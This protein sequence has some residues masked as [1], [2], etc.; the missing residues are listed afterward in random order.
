MPAVPPAV[1]TFGETWCRAVSEHGDRPFLVFRAD[2]GTTTSWTYAEF[3]DVVARVAGTLRAR[4]VVPGTSVHLVLRS[5]PAFVAL[6]LAVARLGAWMVP[7]DPASAARDVAGQVR[8]VQPVLGVAAAS[9]LGVYT[10]GADGTPVVALAE[11]ATDLAPGAPLVSEAEPVVAAYPASPE[12]RLAVMFTSGTTSEPKGV[13]LTQACYATVAAAMAAAVDLRPEH[14][15]YVT[16]PMFHANAQYYCFAPAVQVGASVAMTASF[17]ASGWVS[18]ARDLEVTHASLFAAPVRMILARC[19]EDEEPLALQHVWYAQSLGAEH[20]RR[21]GALAGT[22]PRQL[23]GMTETVAVVTADR[24]DPPVHDLIGPPVPGRRV[25]LVDAAG[26]IVTQAG[27]PGELQVGGERGRDLFA[28]YLDA[29]EINARAFEPVEPSEPTPG[30]D[31]RRV[32][33]RTGDLAAWEPGVDSLRFVGRVDDVIKVAGENVSLTEVEAAL[34]QA[35]G[36]LEVAVV[37]Q[38]D[39][40][41]DQVPVAYVVA[42]DRAAPPATA[43]LEAYAVSVLA[44]AARPRAW[45]LIDELPRTGVGK[46]RRF[47]V[48]SA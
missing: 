13:V 23:Y 44:P 45:H 47:R 29:P 1:S 7:V 43:D 46:V 16:L 11:D 19:P 10:E 12:H 30:G 35:P 28:G 31:E 6:W 9:R 37:A 48:G 15:W 42:K 39:P 18:G 34:A 22:L 4:G 33:F 27:V 21:F 5:C 14:R 8:R 20:H 3:D 24:N 38:P 36:V 25:R 17:S 2:D 32:W 40:V 26:G 41:R